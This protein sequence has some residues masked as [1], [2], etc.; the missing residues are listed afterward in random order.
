[1]PP[2]PNKK[3]EIIIFTEIA[4]LD[5]AETNETPLVSSKSPDKIPLIYMEESPKIFPI[6]SKIRL[7]ISNTLLVFKIEIITEKITTNPPI[8]TIVFTDSKIELARTSP[9]L[10]K[11]QIV[12]SEVLVDC[13]LYV[14]KLWIFVFLFLLNLLKRPE[15]MPTVIA[16]YI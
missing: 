9:K 16:D 4:L 14:I 15:I 3:A 5:I 13:F 1:M 10:E 12:F 2:K 7:H 6:G 8:I 11:V